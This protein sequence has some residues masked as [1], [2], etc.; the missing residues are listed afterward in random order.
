VDCG[1]GILSQDEHGEPLAE[2]LQIQIG[3]LAQTE[4]T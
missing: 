2:K 4:N 1:L 3:I